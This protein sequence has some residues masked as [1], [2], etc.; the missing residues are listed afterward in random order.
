METSVAEWLLKS[1][2]S[3][4]ENFRNVINDNI[5]VLNVTEE[6]FQL[7]R[8]EQKHYVVIISD[9][10]SYL[11]YT[12]SNKNCNYYSVPFARKLLTFPMQKKSALK[13]KLNKFA[14]SVAMFGFL[15]R[16]CLKYVDVDKT[17]ELNSFTGNIEPINFFGFLNC[18]FVLLFGCLIALCV[19]LWEIIF[20]KLHKRIY[21]K[22][23][24]SQ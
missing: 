10:L 23:S 9:Q 1:N 2:S 14:N 8:S 17:C 16:I 20:Y 21:R 5:T 22:Y 7:I 4:Y 24:V 13:R 15:N 3:E 11:Y 19:L 18:L 6:A 12:D